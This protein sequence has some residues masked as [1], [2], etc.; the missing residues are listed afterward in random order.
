MT[1]PTEGTILALQPDGTR[2]R[3]VTVERQNGQIRSA[4]IRELEPDTSSVLAM[5]AETGRRW[6][7]DH[8]AG[9]RDGGANSSAPR[10]VRPRALAGVGNP[11]GSFAGLR[12]PRAPHGAR[13]A[14]SGPGRKQPHRRP[15]QLACSDA[16]QRTG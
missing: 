15:D 12:T 8:V 4:T 10:R 3:A 2:L 13:V 1:F 9:I 11:I 6:R 7:S 5:V 14:P 16:N